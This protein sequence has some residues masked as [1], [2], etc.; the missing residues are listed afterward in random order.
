MNQLASHVDSLCMCYRIGKRRN[1]NEYAQQVVC[2]TL[3]HFDKQTDFG[4]RIGDRL[5]NFAIRH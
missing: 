5:R 4:T 2:R 1:V 3:V